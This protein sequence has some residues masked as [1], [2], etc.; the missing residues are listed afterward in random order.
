MS[1]VDFFPFAGGIDS[2]SPPLSLKA[3]GAL[4]A[5]NYECGLYGGYHRIDGYERFNGMPSPSSP[6]SAGSLPV[7]IEARRALITA[8]QGSGKILGVIVYKSV[9]YAFRN[10]VAGTACVMHKS[11]ATGWQVVTTP[12]L[13]PSGSY[14]FETYN[15][16][17]TA[18]T[19]MVFGCDGI[20]PAF[21]FDGVTF[22]QISTGMLVDTPTHII[23]HKKHLF[24]SFA[25]GSIQHSAIGTPLVWTP[26]TG[27]AEIG[28]GDEC[29]GFS[30]Q[31][32]DALA[33]FTRSYTFMLYGTSV[34]DWNLRLFSRTTGA[35]KNSMTQL[36]GITLYADDRGVAN[37]QT[38]QAFG[39][40]IGDSISQAVT[41]QFNAIKSG[42]S[43]L[44]L[45]LRDKG[46]Y[47]LFDANGG[48]LIATFS[49]RQVSGWTTT[50]FAHIPSCTVS[51][52][53]INGNEI[54]FFGATDG[55]V[56]QMER[57]T[58][59]DGLPIQA[60]LRLPFNYINS[61]RLRKRFRKLVIETQG[62]SNHVI[63]TFSILFDKGQYTVGRPALTTDYMNSEPT[64]W[65][66]KN[67]DTF[68]W[69]SDMPTSL[70]ADI[71]G[72]A[73][74]IGI[75]IYSNLTYELPY[76]LMGAFIHY[77]AR[78]VDRGY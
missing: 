77:D 61:P 32:G 54:V 39:D 33:I 1:K 65:N 72:T 15:F 78:R 35:I 63:L 13:L 26:I 76:D 55:F 20:N 30:E 67:W 11:S 52:D 10:N 28:L 47:R 3:G 23:A 29:T 73:K 68:T 18:N 53:D 50:K 44:S 34:I 64:M 70:L 66:T 43:I 41:P 27:A 74:N 12:V 69:N 62:A 19:L 16:A 42:G 14:Q 2:V 9:V 4:T 56:Y 48:A 45:A 7:D 31:A 8:V 59:F 51:G 25:G 75:M 24:L 5:E 46:Q 71:N 40:F 57:G 17:G 36:G 22:T 58:S 49:G 38:T 60:V 37:L 6:S 21:Q